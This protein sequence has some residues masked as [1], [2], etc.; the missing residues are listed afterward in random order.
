MIRT[1]LYSAVFVLLFLGCDKKDAIDPCSYDPCKVVAPAAQIQSV[2]DYLIANGITAVQ[3]CS[4]AFYVIDVQGTGA[5]PGICS[6]VNANYTGKLTNGT[7]FDQGTFQEPLQ[8]ASL[9]MGWANTLP[10]LQKGGKMRM[11]LPPSL[12]YGAQTVG[13]IPANS[14]LIFD[15]ELTFVQ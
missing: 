5:A 11:F 10:Q 8:L 9:I 13:T 1:F 3:H 6:Y 12:G 14:I 4:G 7:V 2:K 15:I